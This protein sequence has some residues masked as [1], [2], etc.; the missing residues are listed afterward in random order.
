MPRFRVDTPL[1]ILENQVLKHFFISSI[2]GPQN[3][4]FLDVHL[5]IIVIIYLNTR[6]LNNSLINL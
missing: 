5:T 1:N 4:Y 3:V 2:L 6:M